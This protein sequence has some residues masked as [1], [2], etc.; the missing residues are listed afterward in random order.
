MATTLTTIPAPKACNEPTCSAL[1]NVSLVI[2]VTA[3]ER[4]PWLL[5][6]SLWFANLH[7]M[8][9]TSECFDCHCR[10]RQLPHV[11][12]R[13]TKCDCPHGFNTSADHAAATR[14][15]Q[16]AAIAAKD[17]LGRPVAGVLFAH[18]DMWLNVRMFQGAPL[19][20]VW[21]P[22][23]GLLSLPNAPKCFRRGSLFRR[24]V[25]GYVV[26]QTKQCHGPHTPLLPSLNRTWMH[27]TLA[28]GA[29]VR[30]LKYCCMGWADMYYV[31][32][33]ALDA[34]AE[35]S[36]ALSS[37]FLEVAIPTIANLLQQEDSV[38]WYKT[39]CSGDCCH[40]LNKPSSTTPHATSKHLVPAPMP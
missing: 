19:N 9:S 2:G 18:M 34:F 23:G 10:V 33:F 1:A 28:V 40:Q 7:L 22:N 14:G 16:R 31:P 13:K 20:S 32:W 35:L 12:R 27:G 4:I 24:H 21:S 6:Y 36:N 39:P 5:D 8:L 25:P 30:P 11:H 15:M 29:S 3:A 17:L 37:E 38:P 26:A